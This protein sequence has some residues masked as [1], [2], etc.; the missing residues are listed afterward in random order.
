MRRIQ[1]V[2]IIIII[3]L[4]TVAQGFRPAKTAPANDFMLFTPTSYVVKPDDGIVRVKGDL[5]GIPHT[6]SRIDAAVLV[7]GTQTFTA[8]DID[9]VDFE[10]YFQWEDEGVIPL[11]IDFVVPALK[12]NFKIK[13]S[14]KV[15]FTT[16]RGE[17]RFAAAP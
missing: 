16:V 15:V 3:A 11:E 2:L 1:A 7:V 6:S 8:Q 9:G 12:K 5:K 17:K 13:P 10:R 14:D 4:S